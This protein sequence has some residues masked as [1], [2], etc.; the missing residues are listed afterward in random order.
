MRFNVSSIIATIL[1]SFAAFAEEP[2]Q[3]QSLPR[4]DE[5]QSIA[6]EKKLEE[7]L[8]AEHALVP[9]RPISDEIKSISKVGKN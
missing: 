6:S 1:L 3:E 5:T 8:A 9:A 2:T 4:K 7:I